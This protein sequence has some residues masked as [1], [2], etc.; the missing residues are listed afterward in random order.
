METTALS[1]SKQTAFA[2]LA[3]VLFLAL[4]FLQFSFD[5]RPLHELVNR[6]STGVVGDLV[7]LLLWLGLCPSAFAF[8]LLLAVRDLK[9][10]SFIAGAVTLVTYIAEPLRNPQR[11]IG[12]TGAGLDIQ[13]ALMN[14]GVIFVGSIVLFLALVALP[15]TVVHLINRKK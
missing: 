12:A 6:W 1:S 3:A 10:S 2:L 15:K 11:G 14:A 9:F 4:E 8:P 7:A 5:A 13:T